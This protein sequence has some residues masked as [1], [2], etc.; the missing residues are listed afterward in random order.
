MEF[1]GW[2]MPLQFSGISD[3]HLHARSQAVIFD[4]SH[5]GEIL[6]CGPGAQE[7]LNYAATN[8]V[9]RI[10][11][12]QAQYSLLLN[13]QGGV[14]DDIIIYQL[15]LNSYLLCV[16]ASNRAKDF[17]WLSKIQ[18]DFVSQVSVED[19]SD[20]YSQI[21]LQGPKAQQCLT[22]V[23]DLAPKDAITS[24]FPA[25]T[26]RSLLLREDIS[27]GLSERERRVLVARTGYTGED[28][29][30]IYCSPEVA[31]SVW[32]KLLAIDV[33]KPA[34]LGARDTLR[35]EAAYPLRGHELRD[36]IVAMSSRVGRFI[37]MGKDSF[38]G[39]DALEAS[40]NAKPQYQLAGF[41]LVDPGVARADCL[42]EL[43]DGKNVGWVSSGTKTPSLPHPIALAFVKAEVLAEGSPLFAN[44]R[45]RHLKLERTKT[46]FYS[47]S[48]L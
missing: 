30:E 12:G 36:D 26:H 38:L 42:V 8:N 28:G 5:M 43:G 48:A 33:V 39:K 46:P 19:V 35:L 10:S 24:A 41:K 1:A 25:F 14:V 16:N 20:Q 3:E 13:E 23:V 9:S 47:R 40:V 17:L 29:F 15:A 37:D 44:V 32:R 7:F 27:P 18:S 4:V 11:P 6:V 22:D 45:G 21:A 2:E 34:G 31:E